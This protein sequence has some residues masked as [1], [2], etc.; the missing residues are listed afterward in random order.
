[1]TVDL[2]EIR[3]AREE[4]DCLCS[5]E[6]VDQALGRLASDITARLHDKNPLVYTVMNGGL[7]LAGRDD[8]ART[9][10]QPAVLPHLGECDETQLGITGG[11]ELMRLGDVL[12]L[13]Q[14][15]LHRFTDALSDREC[16]LALSVSTVYFC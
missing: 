15:A 10:G 11:D 16:G 4:A 5:A 3:R 1:M 6:D 13:D 8:P 9:A 2:D 12:A 14:L 7:V